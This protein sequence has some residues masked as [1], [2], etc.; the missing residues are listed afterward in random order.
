MD[1][2][3]PYD[4]FEESITRIGSGKTLNF[5]AAL[6]PIE[7]QM[8]LEQMVRASPNDSTDVFYFPLDDNRISWGG[9]IADSEIDATIEQWPPEVRDTRRYGYFGGFTGGIYT[10]FNPEI[11]VVT[12]E[13]ERQLFFPNGKIGPDMG[14]VGACDWGG[15]NPFVFLW[16]T[17]IDSLDGDFYIFDELYH[18]HKTLGGRL[19]KDL[20]NDILERNRNWGGFQFT[21]V[22]ADHDP[23]DAREFAQYGI[24]SLKAK[25]DVKGG[26]EYIQTLLQPKKHIISNTWPKGR[27]TLHIASRCKYLINEMAK[28][29]WASGTD[30]HDP[31]DEPLKVDDHACFVAGT[32]VTTNK[33]DIP[34]EQIKEGMMILTRKG[35]KKCI[36]SHL[37]N[38]SACVRMI[39]LSNGKT[40]IATG[41]HPVF[42]EN[43][44]FTPVDSL[45]L[46]NKLIT[47]EESCQ[48]QLLKQLSMRELHTEDIQNQKI[49]QIE[50]TLDQMDLMGTQFIYTEKFG[51]MPMENLCQKDIISTIKMGILEIILLK[52]WNCSLATSIYP[53][54]CGPQR[55]LKLPRKQWLSHRNMQKNGIIPRKEEHGMVNMQKNN[56]RIESLYQKF[57]NIVGKPMKLWIIQIL[58]NFVVIN[59]DPMLE[60][61]AGLIMKSDYVNDAGVHLPPTSTLG[62]DF[63]PVVVENVK[64][65]PYSQ[66][67]YNITVDEEHEYFA[68]GV[69]VSNCDAMRYLCYGERYMSLKP[70]PIDIQVPRYSF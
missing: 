24:P 14:V 12:P 5:A 57:V 44:G 46:G 37:T 34:I 26:I 15:N 29:R 33:G 18:D 50:N 4:I 2:Q 40:V 6:T 53:N 19:L 68:N 17:R 64:T 7:P 55:E 39:L 47:K 45:K 23:T 49:C 42:V 38:I 54:I 20:A 56:T 16:G 51:K 60:E 62:S 35:Y 32:M 30:T 59:V 10:T 58:Q 41:N 67:V 25:K 31:K 1:E 27:P 48:T 28:Y 13:K 61:K 65:L 22:W 3:M 43:Q 63:V 52:I 36:A 9:Y 8:W 66:P 11:H 70:S 69:L 21:R